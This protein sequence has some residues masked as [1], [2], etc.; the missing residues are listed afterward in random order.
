M[1]RIIVM[2]AVS[3]VFALA[4]WAADESKKTQWVGTG[5]ECPGEDWDLIKDN[6]KVQTDVG[7]LFCSNAG[8][9]MERRFAARIIATS[10]MRVV[11][12]MSGNDR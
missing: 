11:A 4:A 10:C 2:V 6:K 8:R 7:V 12:P 5:G 1:R 9:S 3:F